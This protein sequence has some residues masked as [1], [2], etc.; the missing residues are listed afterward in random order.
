MRTVGYLREPKRLQAGPDQRI[1]LTLLYPAWTETWMAKREG[2]HPLYRPGGIWFG[3]RGLQRSRGRRV[4]RPW[5][6][7]SGFQR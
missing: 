3:I 1:E 6:T 7:A 5:R 4:S 2:H